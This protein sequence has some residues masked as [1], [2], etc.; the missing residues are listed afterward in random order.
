MKSPTK[1][2]IVGAGGI[3]CAIAPL[4]SRLGDIV[5]ID[6]D[7]YEPKNVARQFPALTSNRNKAETLA[8]MLQ[9]HT[10][11]K[12]EF[13]PDWLRDSSICTWDEW[14]GVDCIIGGVDNNES[15]LIITGLADALNIPAILAGNDHEN[16]EAHLFFPGVYDPLDHHD[17][18]VVPHAAPWGCNK[19][20]VIEEFPQTP[21]ANALAAA[22]VM[23]ILLSLRKAKKPENVICYSRLDPFSSIVKRIRDMDTAEDFIGAV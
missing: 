17:F 19:D 20:S 11:N 5:I 4:L 2:A 9:P 8:G 16:G 12:V 13:I 6:A 18:P 10:L 23:H 22:A 7:S 14:K 3:G 1:Y 15:R 21:I